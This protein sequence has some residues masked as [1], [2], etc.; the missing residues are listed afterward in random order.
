MHANMTMRAL[1]ACVS[2][3]VSGE[4]VLADSHRRFMLHDEQKRLA[5]P[6]SVTIVSSS[7]SS[8]STL[9]VED[10]RNVL[11]D[12]NADGT[13]ILAMLGHGGGQNFR[14]LLFL[15]GVDMATIDSNY[16]P[17]FKIADPQQFGIADQRVHY[18]AKL[19]NTEL[20]VLAAP[21]I[22]SIYDLRG[23]KV[24]FSALLSASALAADALFRTLGIDVIPTYYD[25][26][27]AIERMRTGEIAAAV[28]MGV[29][30]HTDYA[31]I[32]AND[33]F[34]LLPIDPRG[35]TPQQIVKLM[36]VY[37][38]AELTHSHYPNLIPRGARVPTIAGSV[39]LAV[40]NW[41]EGSERYEKAAQ[42][43]RRFFGN[44]E[45]FLGPTRH[46][47][48]REVN[49]A[50][51]VPGWTRFKAA[52][53]WLDANRARLGLSA[54]LQ[55]DFE[56]FLNEREWQSGGRGLSAPERPYRDFDSWWRDLQAASVRN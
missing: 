8:V 42:F 56:R 26:D 13:R 4:G 52:Q 54:S 18:I 48:W 19:Y 35:M 16:L 32:T 5:N 38:P 37:V 17:H 22:R 41:P 15:R 51:N 1:I 9:F 39:V 50:A 43:V 49:L 10:M 14:D 55:A 30:P 29:A 6:N 36:E 34:H 47:K 27:F 33:R 25:S 40:Y 53:E 7:T 2:I 44:F 45:R 46:P 3:V 20:H 21:H 24:N 31:G 28:H 23:R 11:D 12:L